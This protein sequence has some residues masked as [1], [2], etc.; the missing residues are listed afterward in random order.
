MSR[1]ARHVRPNTAVASL[2]KRVRM[3]F[4]IAAIAFATSGCINPMLTRL[5][6]W[7]VNHPTAESRAY[8]QQ[9]PFPDP[10]IGPDVLSRPRGYERPRTESRK[11]AE[12]RLL[13][14][15]PNTPENVPGGYPRGGLKRP[16]AVY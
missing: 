6:T 7:W 13:Y 12:L 3:H 15:S 11:A 10:D 1:P 4:A 14:G 16:A 2:L 5:P 8:Q 9:D